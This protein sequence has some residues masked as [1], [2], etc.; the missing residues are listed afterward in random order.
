MGTL[1]FTDYL[2]HGN[3]GK[4][5]RHDFG[6]RG[7]IFFVKKDIYLV[8]LVSLFSSKMGRTQNKIVLSSGN[9][10]LLK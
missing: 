10:S 3:K 9:E 1:Y 6:F 7:H 4:K 5:P 8:D 2:L